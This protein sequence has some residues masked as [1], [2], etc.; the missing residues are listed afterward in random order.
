ML[1]GSESADL[2]FSSSALRSA[3]SQRCACTS[4]MTL[5]R[6]PCLHR[7]LQSLLIGLSAALPGCGWSPS[8]LSLRP[9]SRWMPGSVSSSDWQRQALSLVLLR[10]ARYVVLARAAVLDCGSEYAGRASGARQM[11]KSSF[12]L[13]ACSLD[14][15]YPWPS[16]LLI[17]PLLQPSSPQLAFGAPSRLPRTTLIPSASLLQNN[18]DLIWRS[19]SHCQGPLEQW[20]T[21]LKVP[22]GTEVL[23]VCS[24]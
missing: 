7:K 20:K 3:P 19:P 23:A 14:D 6:R 2:Q 1:T 9:V 22:E 12:L 5:H 18:G 17:S 8:S 11:R 15:V 13:R 4:A 21:R 10:G 16:Y 24:D